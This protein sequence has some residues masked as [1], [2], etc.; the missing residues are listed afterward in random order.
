MKKI[1]VKEDDVV[2]SS[3]DREIAIPEKMQK[4]IKT[5]NEDRERINREIDNALQ[6]LI[7]GFL[8]DKD[9]EEN[10]QI[11]LTPDF[12]SIGLKSK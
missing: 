2:E 3:Y 9:V 12:K 6:N 8:V 7:E 10:M 4:R 1:N 11:I 5:L